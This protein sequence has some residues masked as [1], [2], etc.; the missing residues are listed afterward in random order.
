MK[1]TF[2]AGLATGLFLFS[3][4]S[5]AS[6]TLITSGTVNYDGADRKL[7]YDTDLDITWLDYTHTSGN[8]ASQVDWADSLSFTIDNVVYDNWRLPSAGTNPAWAYD[9]TSSEM[10]H[11]FYD[12]LG[13]DS[14][15]VGGI[16]TTAKL[17][18]SEFDNLIASWYWSGTEYASIYSA[19]YF[20][21]GYGLQRN[22]YKT[23]NYYG[24]AVFSGQVSPVP[25]PATML[26]FGTGIA[27]LAGLSR[28]RK[29]RNI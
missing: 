26:L 3:L 9:Q 5:A 2:L 10:G 6:A 14:Y 1:K 15:P 24:L 20:S 25:E 23:G 8:W 4:A 18:A 21:T 13:L 22:D 29:G 16:T 12:E 17:N 28:R 19:W 11:L 27:G 7:I